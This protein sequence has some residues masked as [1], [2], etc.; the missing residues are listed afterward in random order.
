MDKDPSETDISNMSD[1]EFKTM[2]I[3]I[4]FGLEKRMED[5]SETPKI[6]KENNTAEMK[7]TINKRQ[8]TFDGMKNMLEEA[9]EQFSDLEDEEWKIINLNI[10]KKTRERGQKIYLKK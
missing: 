9:K 10:S 7:G 5:M 8:N 2:F 4:L 3:R 6:E 1:R